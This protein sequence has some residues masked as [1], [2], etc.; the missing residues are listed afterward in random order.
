MADNAPA[1]AEFGIGQVTNT[2]IQDELVKHVQDTYQKA[3]QHKQRTGVTDRLLSNLRS[4]LCEYS[5]A[6]RDLLKDND[7]F[8]G[9]GALKQR[10][11]E[12]WLIDII[13]NNIDKPWTLQGTPEPTLPDRLKA[14]VVDMLIQEL[15]T[16]NTFDALKD[17]AGQLKSAV[18]ALAARASDATVKRMENHIDDQLEEGGFGDTYAQFVGQLTTYPTAILRGPIEVGVPTATWVGD[19]LQVKRG[20]VL[21]VRTV[22]PFDAFPSADA[23]SA[24][25]GTAFV[26]RIDFGPSD[27]HDLIGVPSF[28]AGNIRAALEKYSDGHQP[29][30]IERSSEK[31]LL[32]KEQALDHRTGMEV[33]ILNGKVKGKLL[34]SKGVIVSD[35][36]KYYEC[37]VWTVGEFCIRAVLNPNP[38]GKRPLYSTSFVKV[39]G[40]FWGKGV[41]DLVADVER[42]C[43]AACRAIVRN[44]GY[45][46]GPIGE[47][48]SDR[49]AEGDDP[50]DITPYN[51]FRVGPD[52][53]GTGAPAFKFHNVTAI[54]SDLMA[55]FEKYM[56]L[57]DDLSGVPAYVLGNPQVAG[58]GR[59]L[60]GLS[61]LMGDLITPEPRSACQPF[62]QAA[63]QVRF[64]N[65]LRCSVTPRAPSAAAPRS[66]A[67][68][69]RRRPSSPPGSASGRAGSPG[70][71][72]GRRRPAAGRRD[73][74]P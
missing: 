36:Q 50:T 51:I 52:L 57:A 34:A 4:K 33:L 26:E 64:S 73:S 67:T 56:K 31:Q 38:L 74:P 7:I 68:W 17:R 8:V 3:K 71:R 23:T 46:S 69:R 24:Q 53:T 42:I 55:V 15:P 19:K 1:L 44:M 59:T 12:S 27:I 10:A 14:K 62:A 35:P 72:A 30:T 61:M 43:N 37:E 63:G 13:V 47:V 45:A 65:F 20:T 2:E 54:G 39:D 48:V 18:Q 58:A 16:F 60:G 21:K 70:W 9:I 40:K 22:S 25:N 6:D 5:P 29:S 28:N 41:I 66:R 32:E 11:A 49:I